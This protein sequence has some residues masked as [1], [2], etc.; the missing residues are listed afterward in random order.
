MCRAVQK[1]HKGQCGRLGQGYTEISDRV[2]YPDEKKLF[3]EAVC[4]RL[5][6]TVKF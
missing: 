3:C 5:V 2:Y 6:A 1:F 4:V